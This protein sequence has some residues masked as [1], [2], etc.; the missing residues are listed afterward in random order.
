MVLKIRKK[1][2]LILPKKLRERV[3]IRENDD[4]VVEVSGDKLVIRPLRPRVVDVD[5][6]VVEELLREEH[7][8]EKKKYEMMFSDRKNSS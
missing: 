2:I 5:P 8:L 4:V 1:G 7:V 3:G 6:G